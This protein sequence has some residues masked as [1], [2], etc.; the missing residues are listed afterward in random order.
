MHHPSSDSLKQSVRD[1]YAEVARQN[2]EASSCCGPSS[3]A[4]CCESAGLSS[5]ADSYEGIEGYV[6]E[7]DLGLGC[8][9]PTQFAHLTEGQTVLDLGSGAGN[10]CF[11]ARREVGPGGR[12]IG[13]DFTPEMVER[14]RRNAD[15][16]GYDNVHFY[17]GDIEALP[18]DD[19]AVDVVV[20][21]CVLALAPDK[22]RVYAE[23]MRVLRPGGHF[24]ISDVVT[25][26]ALPEPMR[27]DAALYAG[28]IGGAIDHA[29]YLAIIREAGFV[30]VQMQQFKP[31]PLPDSVLDQ[32]LSQEEKIRWRSEEAGI[33]SI[34]VYG[35]KPEKG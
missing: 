30:H 7:A 3:A 28:C 35:A 5:L 9:L 14:A 24:S 17:E 4:S 16:L 29:D 26:G 1:K 19:N 25:R 2:A 6:D 15:K 27:R 31:K 11:I 34:T 13:V 10:D 20:S 12:V 21:N 23:T 22:A 18:L 8:G 32:H 33:F